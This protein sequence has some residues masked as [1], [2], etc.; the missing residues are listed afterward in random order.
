M[1]IY[2]YYYIYIYNIKSFFYKY[3]LSFKKN[4]LIINFILLITRILE[5]NITFIICKSIKCSTQLFTI[6]K[7]LLRILAS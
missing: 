5:H 3:H 6:K 2:N 1:I 7:N 4:S